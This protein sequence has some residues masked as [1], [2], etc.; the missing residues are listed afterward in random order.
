[1]EKYS[2]GGKG[3]DY[4]K[5]I[6]DE[7]K[8]FIDR[9]YRT[10]K[11]RENTAIAGSSLGGLISFYIGWNY[12]DVFKKIGAVSPSFWWDS[13]NMIK[14]VASYSGDKKDLNIWIDAGNAEENGDRD[15]NGVIDM[16]DD[17]REMVNA[18]NKKGF[19]TFKDVMYYEATLGKHNE[20]AW[21]KRFDQILLYMF[22]KEKDPK[23]K[24]LE[25]EGWD[26]IFLSSTIPA[27]LNPVITYS[28]GLKQ[29]VL[30]TSYKGKNEDVLKI[31]ERGFITPVK[32]GEAEITVMGYG[33]TT[34]KIIKVEK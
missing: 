28:N 15:N 23:P 17:A 19:V 2:K 26:S 9:G 11:H 10:Q 24:T 12:P 30:D 7:V 1:M 25:T 13:G 20:E 33:L 14:E 4:A 22:G 16:V 29:S 34:K 3:K 6:V 32:E 21:A 5:F 27:Y 31:D 18:L 8:P